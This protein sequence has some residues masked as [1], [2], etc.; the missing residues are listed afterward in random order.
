[1]T[2]L[3]SLFFFQQ[4]P[5]LW[6][7]QLFLTTTTGMMI[8]ST[9]SSLSGRRTVRERT[10][11]ST[12]AWDESVRWECWCLCWKDFLGTI[13]PKFCTHPLH[14]PPSVRMIKEDRGCWWI[15]GAPSWKLVSSALWLGRTA[16]I[17][18]LMI[19]VGL[20]AILFIH[21]ETC[22]YCVTV[23]DTSVYTSR[24]EES[25][26]YWGFLSWNKDRLTCA[27]KIIR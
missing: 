18:T 13:Q 2:G 10:R 1:M 14:V 26:W 20:H 22:F 6:G 24:C 4:S 7:Q 5:S 23:T 21:C 25:L 19:S 15:D 11:P 3:T 16:S 9:S 12:L 8:K 17:H 27:E